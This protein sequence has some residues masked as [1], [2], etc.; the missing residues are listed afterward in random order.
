MGVVSKLIEN[1]L[2]LFLILSLVLSLISLIFAI[3]AEA[4]YKKLYR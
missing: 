3:H 1:A 2:P 4:K